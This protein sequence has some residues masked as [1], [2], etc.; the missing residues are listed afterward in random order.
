MDTSGAA[1]CM[2]SLLESD[3]NQKFFLVFFN[4][5]SKK[6]ACMHPIQGS[7]TVIQSNLTLLFKI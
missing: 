1:H 3:S 7:S 2:V 6:G 5:A 4:K